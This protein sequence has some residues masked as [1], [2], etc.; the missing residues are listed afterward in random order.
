MQVE[1]QSGDLTADVVV[2]AVAEGGEAPRGAH[3]QVSELL[4]SGEAGTDFG[5]VT[6]TVVDGQRIAVAGLGRRAD[7]DAVRT[8]VAGAARDTRR[9]GGTL[10]YVVNESLALDGAEQARAAADGLVFGTYD[11]RKWRSR[12]I[13]GKKEFER[14]PLPRGEARRAAAGD[15]A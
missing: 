12:E 3:E 9:V 2:V 7:A 13:T 10:A 5:A 4:A 11:T 14:L 1:A 15:S 8:A 6:V